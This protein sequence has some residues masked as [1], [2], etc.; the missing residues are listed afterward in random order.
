M[1]PTFYFKNCTFALSKFKQK[2]P[3]SIIQNDNDYGFIN[4]RV[5]NDG[6]TLYGEFVNNAG[7]VMDTFQINLNSKQIKNLEG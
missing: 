1:K 2:Q 6:K 3:W 5:V 4:I 7:K